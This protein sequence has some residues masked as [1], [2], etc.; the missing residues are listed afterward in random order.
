MT[1]ATDS[2]IT[3]RKTKGGEWVAFG[4][5]SAIRPGALVCVTKRDG[6]TKT[7]HIASVGHP[8]TVDGRQMVYG[9]LTP[10][11]APRPSQPCKSAGHMCDECGERRGTIPARDMSGLA[12]MVCGICARSGALSFA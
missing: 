11:R 1:T 10:S 12:G 3:Y 7:E 9:Y 5:A 2:G 6:A 4:P 8:F